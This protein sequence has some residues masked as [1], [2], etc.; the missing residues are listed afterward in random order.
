MPIRF[1]MLKT[2]EQDFF[3]YAKNSQS[4]SN[5]TAYKGNSFPTYVGEK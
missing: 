3:S 5:K 2:K 1:A 4:D